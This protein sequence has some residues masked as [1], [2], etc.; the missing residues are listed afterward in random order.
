MTR[1][2]CRILVPYV[3]LSLIRIM[4]PHQAIPILGQNAKYACSGGPLMLFWWVQY[5]AKGPRPDLNDGPGDNSDSDCILPPWRLFES[6]SNNGPRPFQSLS[7][8]RYFFRS[9]TYGLLVGAYLAK[10]PTPDFNNCPWDN[11]NSDRILALGVYSSLTQIMAPLQVIPILVNWKIHL[12]RSP[13]YGLLV[14]AISG[15][16]P[17]G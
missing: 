16:G 6:D 7:D 9:P 3:Y 10:G 4:A 11:L 8:G 12:F 13:A 1:N 5:L 14:N 15:Q 2:C 17:Q